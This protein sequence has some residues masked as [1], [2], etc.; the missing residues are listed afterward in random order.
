MPET[1][2]PLAVVEGADVVMVVVVMEE[3]EDCCWVEGVAAEVGVVE[4][5]GLVHSFFSVLWTLAYL[6]DDDVKGSEVLPL[7]VVVATGVAGPCCR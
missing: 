4:A 3:E 2:A 1:L 7:G 6:F 5:A